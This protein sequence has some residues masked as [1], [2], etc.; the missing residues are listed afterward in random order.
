MDVGLGAGDQGGARR[1]LDQQVGEDAEDQDAGGGQDDGRAQGGRDGL[2]GGGFGGALGWGAEPQ[3]AGHAGVVEEGDHRHDGHEHDQQLQGQGVAV[4]SRLED[5]ELGVPA[6]GRGDAGQREQ[7]GRHGDPEGRGAAGQA[8]VVGDQVGWLALADQGDDGERAQVGEGVDQQVD[9]HGLE[10]LLAHRR[11]GGRADRER[12]QHVAGLGDRGVGEQADHVGLSQGDHVAEQHGEGGQD[13]EGW[14]PVA[15]VGGEGH[16]GHLEEAGEPGR[17]GGDRQVGGHRDRG[18]LVGVGGPEVERGR[19]HLEGEAGDDQEHAH[20]GGRLV[21]EPGQALGDGAELE[22]PGEA[23]DQAHAEQ[24]YGRGQHPDEQE[25]ERALVA[26]GVALAEAGGDEA[27]GR[28]DLQRQEQHQQ[29]AGG[30]HQ[31]HAD[32]ARQDQEVELALVGGAGIDVAL[33]HQQDQQQRAKEQALEQQG[34]VVDHERAAEGAAVAR[35]EQ[36]GQGDPGGQ[37]AGD[38]QPAGDHLVPLHEQV[39]HQ[40]QQG[41]AGQDQLG[42]DGVEVDGHGQ[43]LLVFRE[44]VMY[45]GVIGVMVATVGGAQAAAWYSSSGA[46]C[47]AEYMTASLSEQVGEPAGDRRAGQP[48]DQAGGEAEGHDQHDQG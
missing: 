41:G 29:I 24:H 25:L 5:H 30:R 21:A 6:G 11:V 19:R 4:N 35:P 22:R 39:H 10:G 40:H 17:L 26:A 48:Q 38:R 12:D 34:V 23:V 1:V 8:G 16:E 13:G 7:E 43:G 44:P 46:A 2:G 37:G 9:E 31:Q 47:D 14:R 32:E 33:A 28:D 27:G 18:A 36:G 45:P 3:A 20:H 42:K 15:G